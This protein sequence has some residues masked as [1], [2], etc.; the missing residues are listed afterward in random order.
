MIQHKA[1]DVYHD[2]SDAILNERFEGFREDCKRE[3]S[4]PAG[5]RCRCSDQG[6][7]DREGDEENNKDNEFNQG[8]I[9]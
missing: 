7:A 6:C 1:Q 9:K 8:F 5:R 2:I 3:H 4:E